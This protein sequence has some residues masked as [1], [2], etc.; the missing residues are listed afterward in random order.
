MRKEAHPVEVTGML[1]MDS[2]LHN[3]TIADS[4]GQ[5]QRFDLHKATTIRTRCRRNKRGFRRNDNKIRRR[6]FA[7]YAALQRKRVDWLL[8]NVSAKIVLQAK[9]NKQAIVMEDL[10]GIRKLYQKGKGH[11]RDYRFRMNSWSY[12]EL[13]RQ[14]EYKAEWDGVPVIYV[15]PFGTS[16]KCSVCGHQVL[17][18]ENRL[19]HCP[20]CGLT[21]D[22]DVNAARNIVT[23]GL[24]LYLVSVWYHLPLAEFSQVSYKFKS[25]ILIVGRGRAVPKSHTFVL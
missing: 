5:V 23:R 13:G 1:G 25:L 12:A 8:H 9:L 6:L 11:G 21:I 18:E 17:S 4:R 20:N 14:V 24:R 2:N 10:R 7:K 15:R 16:T 19:L 22:R 3:V